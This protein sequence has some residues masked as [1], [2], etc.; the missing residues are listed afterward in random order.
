[1]TNENYPLTPLPLYPFT[2]SSIEIDVPSRLGHRLVL[3][4][5]ERL[6][7]FPFQE[8]RLGLF[9]FSAL[10]EH[11]LTSRSLFAQKVADVVEIRLSLTLRGRRFVC[12]D[13]LKGGIDRQMGATAGARDA[14]AS[15]LVS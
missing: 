13:L 10:A 1:M 5:L 14:H 11:R 15:A 2:P 8:L 7:E 4:L 3:A 12:D 9:V 6:L